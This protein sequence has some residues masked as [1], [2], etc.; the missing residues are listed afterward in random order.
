MKVP[1]G[2]VDCFGVCANSNVS[3]TAC[4]KADAVI[5]DILLIMKKF[6]HFISFID[7]PELA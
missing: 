3:L 2:V 1:I 6:F 7:S 4:E 5:V